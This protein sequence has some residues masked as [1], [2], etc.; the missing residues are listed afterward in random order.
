MS[1]KLDKILDKLEQQVHEL[2][3]HTDQLATAN[4]DNLLLLDDNMRLRINHLDTNLQKE[5]KRRR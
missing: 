2:Q 3:R 1:D 5:I 4:K